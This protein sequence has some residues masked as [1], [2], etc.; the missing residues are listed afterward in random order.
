MKLG[1]MSYPCMTNLQM[2]QNSLTPLAM[3]INI[4]MEIKTE[5]WEHLFITEFLR[6]NY[7]SGSTPTVKSISRDSTNQRNS[8]FNFS[9]KNE[10]RVR[11]YK[12]TSLIWK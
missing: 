2:G 10:I 5:S 3:V 1:K 11:T 7:L 4:A 9:N 8:L 12:K 6:L